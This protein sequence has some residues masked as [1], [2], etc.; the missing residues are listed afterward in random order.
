MAQSPAPP[1]HS[2]PPEKT[3][4]SPEQ[5]VEVTEEPAPTTFAEFLESAPRTQH[6]KFSI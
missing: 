4:E 1:S 6:E 5:P 3:D 2:P